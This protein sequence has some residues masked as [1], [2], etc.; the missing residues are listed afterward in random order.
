MK[1]IQ[2]LGEKWEI[3]VEKIHEMF[4][5]DLEELKNKQ[6]NNAVTEMKDNITRNQ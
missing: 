3:Y 2:D 4:K 5:K 1:M 6:K